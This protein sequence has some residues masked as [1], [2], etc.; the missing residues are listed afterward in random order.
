[1]TGWNPGVLQLLQLAVQAPVEHEQE[2]SGWQGGITHD[3]V[4][5]PQ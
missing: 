1:V 3:C 5:P 2:Y 4:V